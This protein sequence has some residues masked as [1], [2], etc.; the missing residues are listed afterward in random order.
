LVHGRSSLV[1]PDIEAAIRRR[2]MGAD[3]GTTRPGRE[4]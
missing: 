4:P 2:E 1:S 3:Q